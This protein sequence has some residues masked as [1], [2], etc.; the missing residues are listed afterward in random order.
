[1]KAVMLVLVLVGCA[2]QTPPDSM[3]CTIV[4]GGAQNEYL[5]CYTDR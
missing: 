1:M 4:V 2:H 3:N 5:G